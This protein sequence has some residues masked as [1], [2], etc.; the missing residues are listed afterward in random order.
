M[1]CFKCLA[2]VKFFLNNFL[3]WLRD[4]VFTS[5]GSTLTEMGLVSCFVMIWRAV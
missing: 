2:L 4:I 3:H 5:T 1:L